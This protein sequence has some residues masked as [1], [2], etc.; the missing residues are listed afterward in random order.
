MVEIE[1][2]KQDIMEIKDQIYN[3]QKK[4]IDYNRLGWVFFSSVHIYYSSSM[5]IIIAQ[6]DWIC[7]KSHMI[8]IDYLDIF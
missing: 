5:Y 7:L 1:K 3:A 2:C 8:S 4:I 6:R